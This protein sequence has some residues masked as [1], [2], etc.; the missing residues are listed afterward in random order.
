MPDSTAQQAATLFAAQDTQATPAPDTQAAPTS[1]PAPAA[2][3]AATP[4]E[5]Y[6][7]EVNDRTRYK[8]ADEA[9]AG[10][11]EAQNRITQLSQW[12]KLIAAPTVVDPVTGEERGGFGISDPQQVAKLLDELAGLVTSGAYKFDEGTGKLVRTEPTATATPAAGAASTA[13]TVQ[14]AAAG[15]KVAYDSLT[16]E[17]KAHVDYMKKAG[18][19]TEDKLAPIQQ[20]LDAFS[21]SRAADREASVQAARDDGVNILNGMLDTMSVP[22]DED[23][24]N[25]DRQRNGRSDCSS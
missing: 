4:A 10:F 24:R 16:P 20:Q 6:F 14:A 23:L 2:A 5:S 21:Q 19:V 3:P 8:T 13:A 11:T 1:A 12:E 25:F 9:K 15:D 17:W 18:F 7:L 22:K